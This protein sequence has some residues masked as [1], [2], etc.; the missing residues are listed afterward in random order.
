MSETISFNY[1]FEPDAYADDPS[2]SKYVTSSTSN[3]V[4]F[5][6]EVIEEFALFLSNAYGY[7]ITLEYE[8]H[9]DVSKQAEE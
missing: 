9:T 7:K 1:S 4:L 6:G 3:D 2:K 8:T 5:L